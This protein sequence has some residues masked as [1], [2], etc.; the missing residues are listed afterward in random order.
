MINNNKYKENFRSESSLS[1]APWCS[2][3]SITGTATAALLHLPVTTVTTCSH[4]RSIKRHL[5][6]VPRYNRSTL[7]TPNLLCCWPNDL[8]ELRYRHHPSISIRSFCCQLKTFKR[9]EF[10]ILEIFLIFILLTSL[11]TEDTQKTTNISVDYYKNFILLTHLLI[12]DI[13]DNKYFRRAAK[14][15][16]RWNK[17][18][19]VD[20]HADVLPAARSQCQYVDLFPA[21]RRYIGL[22]TLTD[23]NNSMYNNNISMHQYKY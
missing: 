16:E 18:A 10:S 21:G 3:V 22:T 2:I 1:S 20:I 4:L 6:I 7:C 14:L 13:K 12:E 8:E 11:L 5:V 23:H 17:T 9:W 15:T 19:T